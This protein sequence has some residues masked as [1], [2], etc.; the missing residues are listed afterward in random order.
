MGLWHGAHWSF[1]I[2]GIYHAILILVWR[3][4]NKFYSTNNNIFYYFFSYIIFLILIMISWLPFKTQNVAKTFDMWSYIFIPDRYLFL[5]LHENIYI[6][7]SLLLLGVFISKN[8]Y[9]KFLFIKMKLILSIKHLVF[10]CG[11]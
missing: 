3:I 5:S 2:W 6:Y 9:Y 7:L 8:L 10:L 1:V 4:I 11:Q